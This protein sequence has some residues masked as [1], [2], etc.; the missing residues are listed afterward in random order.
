MKSQ[1]EC[2][3]THLILDE[4]HER[5]TEIDFALFITRKLAVTFPDLKIILVSATLQGNLFIEYFRKELGR[6]KVADPYF[7]GIK[8]FPV[9][10]FFIDQL[11]ELVST[12][13]DEEQRVAMTQLQILARKLEKNAPKLLPHAPK[14]TTFTED[15]CMNLIISQPS[16]GDA[17][18]IFHSGLSDINEFCNHLHNKLQRLGVRNR[19]RLFIFHPQLQRA[20]QD[21][22]FQEPLKGTANIIVANRGSESSLTI[23]NLQLVINFGINKEMMYNSAKRISEL[24]RQWCSRASCIQREGRVG[25]VCEGVAVHL[26]TKEFYETLPDFGPPEIIRVPLAK[27]FLRAK[28]IGP[29]LGIPLPSRLLSMVIEPPSFVQFSTALHDLAEYGAIAHSPQQKI[30]EEADVTLLGKFSLSLPLDLSL[31]RLVLFGILFGCPLDGIVIAA[32]TAMYQ[33]VFSMPMKVIMNDLHQFC[34]SLTTSTFSRMKYDD[35]CYSNLIMILNMFIDWLKYKSKDPHANSRDLAFKFSSKNAINPKRLLHLEE[36]VGDIARCVATCIPKDT[37][38][39]SELQ[40]LSK[41]SKEMKEVPVICD[42]DSFMYE[43]PPPLSAKYIPPHIR[44]LKS[45][46]FCS[47][48]VILKALIAAAAPDEILCGE[49]A[50]ESSHP[51]MKSFAKKCISVIENEGFPLNSTLCMDLSKLDEVDTSEKQTQ[52]TDEAAFEKLFSNLSRN[53]QLSVETKVVEDV[54]VLHFEPNTSS[55]LAKTAETEENNSSTADISQISPEV[56]F[57][58]RFGERNILWEID[59]ADS[60]FPAP[61]H[62]CAL[63][64]YRFDESKSKVNTAKLNFRNPT[65]FICQYDKPPQPYFAV[66]T[67]A[68]V[69]AGGIILAPRLTVLPNM[70]RSLMMVLAF[71]LPTSA[72]E[73]LINKKKT[74]KAIK[75]NLV[76][77][78]CTDIQNYISSSDIVAINQ[79]R[80]TV[81]D[82]MALPLTNGCISLSNSA[83]AKIP[84]LLHDL[85]RFR[86]VSQSKTPNTKT[87]SMVDTLQGLVWELVTPGKCTE[88]QS[89]SLFSYYPQ[90]KCSLVGT[91]PYAVEKVCHDQEPPLSPFSIEYTQ[92]VSA[93]LLAESKRIHDQVPELLE[94][95][96]T[97][98]SDGEDGAKT[99]KC[100]AENTKWR[101]AANTENAT[102]D[103]SEEKG[104]T[105]GTSKAV[106]RQKVLQHEQLKEMTTKVKPDKMSHSKLD[107]EPDSRHVIAEQCLVKLE[108]EVIRH[109][110]RNNKMEFLSEL[111]VQRR[112]KHLCSSIGINLDVTFFCKW[113]ELFEIREVEEDEEGSDA[114]VT[115]K[116]YLIILDPSKWEDVVE[117]EGTV[118]PTSVQLLQAASN[119]AAREKEKTQMGKA[120]EETEATQREEQEIHKEKKANMIE[121]EKVK[122]RD[123]REEDERREKK[124]RKRER[125]KEKKRAEKEVVVAGQVA[126]TSKHKSQTQSGMTESEAS[127]RELQVSVSQIPPTN[128]DC[129]QTLAKLQAVSK[130]RKLLEEVNPTVPGERKETGP[131]TPTKIEK[132][133]AQPGTG[134]HIAQF[135]VDFISKHGGQSTLETLREKAFLQYQDKYYEQY[136]YV[137]KEFLRKYD[138][139]EIFEDSSGVC[140]VRVVSGKRPSL[141]NI[142]TEKME[143]KTEQQT[144][145]LSSK[146]GHDIKEH[147]L[148]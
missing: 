107:S 102:I 97:A 34:H 26:F 105:A 20:D 63:M 29:Q 61:S 43:K 6:D 33:D 85:L 144:K 148:K 141:A 115:E 134:E 116:E 47:N 22:A 86:D 89:T 54:A 67:G 96:V 69:S 39:Y 93:K 83:I 114:A 94:E 15:V 138:S 37:V 48:C 38:L 9:K 87:P 1:T 80:T 103:T 109:L 64:W 125:Q 132:I 55:V 74:I 99:A 51:Y 73:F 3:Y 88:D 95:N 71:Q 28:E 106:V 119:L 19:Y 59:L 123:L 78:P 110:Q 2:S 126:T 72:I 76:E 75:I 120:E 49:R 66:A 90:F 121:K 31:C 5:S 7:V 36:F 128:G 60:L 124:K 12:R 111:K 70:P 27:T 77:I 136:T 50:C 21:E 81:S 135:F 46:H 57:F 91:K 56:D 146:L 32:A 137:G 62:P 131:E 145:S 14:V 13:E 82:A 30:S 147:K 16:P 130:D 108:Q 98:S 35:G 53:F 45:L 117:D 65:G 68:F 112:I 58:W 118:L 42:T 101:S 100:L 140:H 25:R 142:E 17:V 92:S 113:P 79:L 4:I 139:F 11:D 52:D 129:K 10:V 44:N 40:T 18:L 122:E 8:R 24:S 23:P 84:K 133:P 41:I 143:L 127:Q 104:W